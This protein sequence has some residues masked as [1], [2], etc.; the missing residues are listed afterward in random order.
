MRVGN[1]R[2]WRLSVMPRTTEATQPPRRRRP[3]M[4][5]TRSSEIP[6][7]GA[8]L[9]TLARGILAAIRS[10]RRCSLLSGSRRAIVA[11]PLPV[12]PPVSRRLTGYPSVSLRL[13]CGLSLSYWPHPRGC[14]SHVGYLIY[15]WKWSIDCLYRR[16]MAGN[17]LWRAGKG[18]SRPT[19]GG[20]LERDRGRE[21]AAWRGNIM[22]IG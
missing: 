21:M 4:S 22:G 19:G 12:T 2:C 17:R 14:Y 20:R 15:V 3:S 9:A 5:R 18:V 6:S 16:T 11:S 10:N 8:R 7:T 13:P 1:Q